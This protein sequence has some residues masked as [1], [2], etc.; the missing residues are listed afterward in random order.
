MGSGILFVKITYLTTARTSHNQKGL[1]CPGNYKLQIKGSPCETWANF[2][3]L[4]R[5][6]QNC[7]DYHVGAKNFSPLLFAISDIVIWNLFVICIL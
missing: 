7:V 4:R 6:A 3:R 5:G 2:I 1:A